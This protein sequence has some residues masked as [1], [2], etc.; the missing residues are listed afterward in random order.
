[1]TVRKFVSFIKHFV[2]SFFSVSV[3]QIVYTG[4]LSCQ[5][6]FACKFLS[7]GIIRK[8]LTCV[9]L[10]F[11]LCTIPITQ[12][13]NKLTSDYHVNLNRHLQISDH[14]VLL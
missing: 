13:L 8:T 2:E 9:K 5:T 11:V 7:S 6:H 10:Y 1:M 12:M 3:T 14:E 4:F